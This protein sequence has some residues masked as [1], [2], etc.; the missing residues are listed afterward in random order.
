M[1]NLTA[2]IPFAGIPTDTYSPA[3]D[4]GFCDAI[5]ADLIDHRDEWRHPGRVVLEQRAPGCQLSAVELAEYT[6][7]AVTVWRRLGH[8]IDGDT[9]LG[10][11]WRGC[12]RPRFVNLAWASQWPNVPMNVRVH[13]R[14][15]PP[16]E[17][18]TMTIS[19]V[20]VG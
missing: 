9:Q 3:C 14:R 7:R 18:M 16:S 5:V 4:D 15:Q 17:Q 2:P 13:R 6:Y 20:G 12:Q 8:V 1:T 10:Y 19:G 11:R